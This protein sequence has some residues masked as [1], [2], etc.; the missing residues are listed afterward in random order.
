MIDPH[1]ESQ[2][3]RARQMID[4]VCRALQLIVN[5]PADLRLTRALLMAADEFAEAGNSM[6]ADWLRS[7]A[8]WVPYNGR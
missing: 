1:L 3:Q 5:T 4:A 7:L 6:G 8:D 2:D